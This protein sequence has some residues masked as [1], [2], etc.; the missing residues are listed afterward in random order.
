MLGYHDNGSLTLEFFFLNQ[1]KYGEFVVR[2]F[3]V[4]LAV[5]DVK[6]ANNIG[7]FVCFNFF[8]ILCWLVLCQ[9]ITS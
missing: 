8:V 7:V 1:W 5:S 2:Q 9:L 6:V 4:F 3:M